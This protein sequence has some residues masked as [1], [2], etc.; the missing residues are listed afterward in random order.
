VVIRGGRIGCRR[1]RG[2]IRVR[3]NKK[4]SVKLC[5]NPKFQIGKN[6]TENRRKVEGKKRNR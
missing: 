2:I 6:V 5:L 3:E 1:G 4:I